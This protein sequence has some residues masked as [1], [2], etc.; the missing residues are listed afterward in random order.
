MWLINKYGAPCNTD[1]V[2]AIT[3]AEDPDHAGYYEVAANN[4]SNTTIA[5]FTADAPMSEA[6]ATNLLG[7]IMTLVGGFSLGTP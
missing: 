7:Q 5:Q 3:V 4:S 6:A 1:Q 2:F